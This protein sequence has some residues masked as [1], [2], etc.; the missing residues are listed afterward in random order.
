MVS[1]SSSSSSSCILTDVEQQLF[2]HDP[3]TF[4]YYQ[5]NTCK[6]NLGQNKSSIFGAR[7]AHL[8]LAPTAAFY[9]H[10]KTLVFQSFKKNMRLKHIV[11]QKINKQ[12]QYT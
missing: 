1:Q 4:W 8:T 12:L 3:L 5:S 2:L 6:D 9:G 11:F 7:L 10:G